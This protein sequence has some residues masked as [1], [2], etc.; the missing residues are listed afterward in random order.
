[1]IENVR[2]YKKFAVVKTDQKMKRLITK[3]NLVDI[4]IIDS[5]VAIFELKPHKVVLN[6]PIFSGMVCLELA[7][8]FMYKFS[9]Q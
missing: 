7:K 5:D 1:M 3:S 8:L 9:F 4:H 2:E 6:K